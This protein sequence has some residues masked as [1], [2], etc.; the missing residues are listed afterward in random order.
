MTVTPQQEEDT[1]VNDDI[2][3]EGGEVSQLPNATAATATAD[4]AI[5]DTENETPLKQHSESPG[6]C[7]QENNDTLDNQESEN[8]DG[9]LIE[10]NNK[11]REVSSDQDKSDVKQG[12]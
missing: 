2:R 7:I 4:E 10:E 12:E 8:M 1:V 11:V 5:P 6:I 9:I 3:I